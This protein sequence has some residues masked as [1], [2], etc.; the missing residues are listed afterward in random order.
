M[1]LNLLMSNPNLEF[2]LSN[3]IIGKSIIQDVFP[4]PGAPTKNPEKVLH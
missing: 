2:N 1:D 3:S 4:I